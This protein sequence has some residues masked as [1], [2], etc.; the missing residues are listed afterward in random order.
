MIIK[1]EARQKTNAL[2]APTCRP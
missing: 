1:A 2:Q